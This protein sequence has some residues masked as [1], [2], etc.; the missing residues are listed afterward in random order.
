MTGLRIALAVT[1]ALA[2]APAVAAAPRPATFHRDVAPILQQRCQTCH[3]PG[4][5]GPMSLLT[6]EQTRPWSKAIRT[7]VLRGEMP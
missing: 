5:I 7:V 6:Y 1:A 4:D 2:V 3:R